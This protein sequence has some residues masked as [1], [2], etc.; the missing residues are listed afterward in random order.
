VRG[1]DELAGVASERAQRAIASGARVRFPRRAARN[2]DARGAELEAMG[3]REAR[4]VRRRSGGRGRPVVDVKEDDGRGC[5]RR[6]RGVG[7]DSRVR[8]AR[9]GDEGTAQ[10]VL[11][12]GAGDG[13]ADGGDGVDDE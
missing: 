10:A 2:R 11:R 13:G 6:G 9:V 3:V 12:E 8:A 1:E 7:E 4:A 5:E